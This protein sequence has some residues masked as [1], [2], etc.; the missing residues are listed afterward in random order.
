L[1]RQAL[2]SFDEILGHLRSPEPV[3]LDL[4]HLPRTENEM[5][6]VAPARITVMNPLRV[7]RPRPP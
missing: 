1:F 4:P 6:L 3:F 5:G 7:P 2:Q